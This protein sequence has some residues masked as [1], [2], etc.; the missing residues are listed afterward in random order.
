ME[1]FQRQMLLLVGFM[2]LLATVF[3]FLFVYAPDPLSPPRM[4]SFLPDPVNDAVNATVQ[5]WEALFEDLG[6]AKEI[7]KS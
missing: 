2:T 6:S 3:L 7:G 4:A 1:T 5:G